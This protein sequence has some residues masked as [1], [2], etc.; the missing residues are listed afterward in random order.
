MT[1]SRNRSASSGFGFMVGTERLAPIAAN[2]LL[3]PELR[4]ARRPRR[5]QAEAAGHFARG[6]G[7]ATPLALPE[8]LQDLLAAVPPPSRAEVA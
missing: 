1:P 6:G 4:L 8:L 2:D 3:P 5:S 7:D